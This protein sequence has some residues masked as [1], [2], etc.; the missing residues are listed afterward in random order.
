MSENNMP[1][2]LDFNI[3]ELELCTPTQKDLELIAAYNTATF[4][5]EEDGR[6]GDPGPADFADMLKVDP[7]CV[8]CLKFE[9]R[10]IAWT[11]VVPTTSTFGNA[12]VTK[13]DKE[14]A[15]FENSMENV[16][17]EHP[18]LEAIYIMGAVTMPGFQKNELS[19]RLLVDQVG[20]F[21][22]ERGTK[23]VFCWLFSKEGRILVESLE[24]QLNIKTKHISEPE[25]L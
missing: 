20:H 8:R 7:Y 11:F 12:F 2:S 10:P 1:E 22:K 18:S 13:K 25:A 3:D 23:D 24:R 21:I 6:Q 19:I 17:S 14:L 5:S 4:D 15:L 16:R 9:D